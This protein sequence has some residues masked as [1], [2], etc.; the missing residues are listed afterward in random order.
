MATTGRRVVRALL[1]AVPLVVLLA[2]VA[3]APAGA[4]TAPGAPAAGTAS[5]TGRTVTLSWAPPAS[6]GG[7][8]LTGYQVRPRWNGQGLTVRTYSS[9]ATTQSIADLPADGDLTFEVAA[10]SAAGTSGWSA[11]SNKVGWTSTVA[12]A[13]TGLAIS[14]T[15]SSTQ[16]RVTFTPPVDTGG[17]PI[18]G[19]RITPYV[20]G[21][22]REAAVYGNFTTHLVSDLQAG[23][24]YTF[25]V[26]TQNKRGYGPETAPSPPIVADATPGLPGAPQIFTATAG[27]AKAYLTWSAPNDTGGVVLTGYDITPY[28]GDV[29]QPVQ[30]LTGTAT[31]GT[32]TGLVN[33]KTY[34]FTVAARNSAGAGAPSPLSGSVTP[35]SLWKPFATPEAFVQQQYADLLSR[36]PTG[37]EL[38]SW[39]AKLR[40]DSISAGW[41]ASS[42]RLSSDHVTHVSPVT[43][44]YFAYYLRLPDPGGLKYW[45]GKKRS[46]RSLGDISN[47]FA[48]SSE[49]TSRYGNMTNRAFVERIYTSVMERTADP[50]GVAYW[51]K[52]LDTR[53][54]NRGQVMI[55]FSESPEYQRGNR[56]EV[57]I[58]VLYALMLGKMPTNLE[59]NSLADAMDRG[60]LDD[61]DIAKRI[62]LLPAY[63]DRVT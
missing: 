21:V 2:V 28:L 54:K 45:I 32:A 58:C 60:S 6:D 48:A 30:H 10:V 41:L 18:T 59:F 50:A 9:T 36:P 14:H 63:A 15:G 11:Q 24:T 7:S 42:L 38:S 47:S 23:Q 40:S 13:P 44:L 5:I 26:A 43:R 35:I 46:G 56:S 3:P 52:Q 19:Y 25:T 16:V 57:A 4:A 20:G 62:Y 39:S 51:T 17:A 31:S 61:W 53:K 22:A 1:A 37:A 34:R 49:F 8:P 33:E 55:G 27:D 12:A 29:A